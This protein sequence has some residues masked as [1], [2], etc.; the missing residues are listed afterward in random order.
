MGLSIWSTGQLHTST[1]RRRHHVL[2]DASIKGRFATH[3]CAANTVESTH[4]PDLQPPSARLAQL[5]LGSHDL[6]GRSRGSALPPWAA[7]CSDGC[8]RH[9]GEAR[10]RFVRFRQ[11]VLKSSEIEGEHLNAQQARSSIARRLALECA[12]LQHSSREIAG[13][14]VGT[15]KFVA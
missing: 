12:G 3:I 5:Y 7:C 13:Q 1:L 11:D 2:L 14:V 6:F 4:G 15:Q 9:R 10:D 8:A